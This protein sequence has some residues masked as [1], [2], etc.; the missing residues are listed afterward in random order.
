VE[1]SAGGMG[2]L[3]KTIIC[4][5]ARYCLKSKFFLANREIRSQK[6]QFNNQLFAQK[7]PLFGQNG[8]NIGQ[9]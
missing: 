5:E 4:K 7:Y 9:K 3:I 1:K 2:V 8:V 6:R